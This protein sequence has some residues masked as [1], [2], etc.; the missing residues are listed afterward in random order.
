MRACTSVL[1]ARAGY[2]AQEVQVYTPCDVRPDDRKHVV[3]RSHNYRRES[4]ATSK[5]NVY[6]V[7]LERTGAKRPADAARG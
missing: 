5:C 4:A 3:H 1:D 6:R 7:A 2:A